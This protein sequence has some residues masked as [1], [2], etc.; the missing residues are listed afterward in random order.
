MLDAMAGARDLLEER[1]DGVA[2]LIFNRPQRRNAITGAMFERLSAALPRLAADDT[3]GVVVL[4]GAGGTFSAGGDIGEMADRDPAETPEQ[5][6][7][8]L[9]RRMD[10]VR[11]LHEM[12][13][14]TIAM[15]GGAAAG[16]GLCLALACDLRIA[17]ATA[18]FA[19]SFARMGYSGDYGGSWFL[20]RLVGLAKAR[21]LYFTGAPIDAAEALRIGLVNRI[22]DDATL[23]DDT[24]RL[25]HELAAGPRFAVA[26]MKRNF[27]LAETAP[28]AAVLDAE[29][30]HQIE[31][32]L[33]EDHREAARAWHERRVPQFKGR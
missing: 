1:A 14:P 6:V 20:P 15:M 33:S 11:V 18:R 10:L 30:A 28:L 23:E 17:G 29:A 5:A 22:V 13:K 24:M 4:A 32:R 27:A 3:V 25:A 31:C 26:R 19:T 2:T 21:E 16:A 8:T 7:Q 9:R 12:P